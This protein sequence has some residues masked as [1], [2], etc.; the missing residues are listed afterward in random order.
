LLKFSDVTLFDV[1]ASYETPVYGKTL[2]IRGRIDNIT[3]RQYWVFGQA[4]VSA[5]APRTFSLNAEVSF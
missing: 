4:Q 1:G 3:D 2:R 5:G